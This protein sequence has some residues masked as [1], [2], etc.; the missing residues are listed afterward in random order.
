MRTPELRQLRYFVMVAEELS[1]TNA[2]G[3]LGIAQQSLS[4]QINVLERT[5]G[6]RLF[7]RDTRGTRLTEVGGLFLPEARTVIERA[8]QAVHTVQRAARG[9]VGR[10]SLAFLPAAKQLLPPVLRAF[11]ARCPDVD[12]AVE[13]VGISQLV[14]GLRAGRYDAGVTHPPLVEGLASRTLVTERMCAVLPCGHPL[15]GRDELRLSDLAE[16]QWV[17][18]ERPAW[19]P[20]HQKYE[21][22]FRDAGF[23]PNVVQRAPN[24]R[25][26]LGLV[27]AGTGV[28]R[29]PESARVPGVVFVPLAGEAARTELVWLPQAG[30]PALRRLVEVTAELA[31]TT[32]VTTTG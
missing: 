27:S 11:R 22:D 15:A 20:W 24:V 32:G 5:L 2:A 8:E 14:T 9:E 4:Q 7:D 18:V 13:D 17:L 1:F 25:D 21:D 12:L 16:E 28:S 10:L 23:E 31:E 26:L 19:P 30:N 29:L 6:V 3:R